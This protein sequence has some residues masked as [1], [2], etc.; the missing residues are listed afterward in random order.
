MTKGTRL[1]ED[2]KPNSNLYTWAIGRR[3]DLNI[4]EQIE[5]F[6][7]YWQ[8]KTGAGATKLDWD[9]TF[10]NW[11]RSA[12]ALPGVVRQAVTPSPVREAPRKLP[13][14]KRAENLQRLGD[15]L[16]GVKR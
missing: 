14:A 11:I 5:M 12:R 16:A 1:P 4:A 6:H 9:R 2:W 10:R 13:E 3:P 15:L 8:A 7:D